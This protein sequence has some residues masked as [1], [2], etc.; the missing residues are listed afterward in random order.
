MTRQEAIETLYQVINSGIIDIELEAKLEEI[1]DC[2]E[3]NYFECG[4]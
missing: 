2:I 3:D 4:E 1:A